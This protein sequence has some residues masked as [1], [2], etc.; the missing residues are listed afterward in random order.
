MAIW[1]A[2]TFL[3]AAERYADGSLSSFVITSS[4]SLTTDQQN[5]Q[6]CSRVIAAAERW[7]AHFSDKPLPARMHTVSVSLFI[8]LVRLCKT[9]QAML[10]GPGGHGSTQ[11]RLGELKMTVVRELTASQPEYTVDEWLN[12]AN[13]YASWGFPAWAYL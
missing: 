4:S 10:A 11:L 13:K 12:R 5:P 3:A 9:H 2:A 6:T 1:G 8:E 7:V